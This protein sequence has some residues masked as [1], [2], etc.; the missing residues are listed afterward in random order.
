MD[1]FVRC[2]WVCLIVSG[3]VWGGLREAVSAP[4]QA[5]PGGG[6]FSDREA[7]PQNVLVLTPQQ[8][9]KGMAGLREEV[10]S[11]VKSDEMDELRRQIGSDPVPIP[12]RLGA[13]FVP[14]IIQQQN[15]SQTSY[16]VY[17]TKGRQ[18]AT[19]P[20]GKKA[21]VYPGRYTVQIGSRSGT[22]LPRYHVR[23]YASQLTIIR[24]RWAALVILVQDESLVQFRGT[25][26]LIHL[27]SRRGIGTGIGADER[28]GEKVRPWLLPPGLYMIVQVG[29][30]YLAR[31]DFLTVQV[32]EGEGTFFRLIKDR[33]DGRVRGG[34]VL[35]LRQLGLERQGAWTW[36]L[37]LSGNFL[38]N[39]V[40][41]VPATTP[42]HRFSLT[43][44]FTGRATYNTERHFF[45]SFLNV[46]LGFTIPNF[47]RID[48]IDLRKSADRVEL[49][50]IYIY[51]I[52]S[53]LGPYARVGLESNI[54]PG[55]YYI[56]DLE[57][58]IGASIF[59]CE[60]EAACSL[61]TDA[62]GSAAD[63]IDLSDFW[64]PLLIKQGLGV[65]LQALQYS[66]LDLR[67]LVGVGFRQEVARAVFQGGATT[68]S[69]YSARCRDPNL[70][71]PSAPWNT[72][73][74]PNTA[75][76][77]QHIHLRFFRKTWSHREGIE[78]AVVATGQITRFLTFTTEFDMLAP[79]TAFD[80]FDIT[81]RT[82][83]TLRLSH[84][85]SLFYR[86][87]VRRDPATPVVAGLDKW[88][89]D[90]SI[91]LSFSILL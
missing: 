36:S 42:G 10:R 65:N 3:I 40:E 89:F 27:E 73:R 57:R 61:L 67:V 47:S 29:D 39:N 80:D 45:R 55:T 74:C 8:L 18:V 48:Q 58:S 25:Y 62:K 49:E 90:Q 85:A 23:V 7:T 82:T 51:R 70:R 69:D 71:D 2:W 59:R 41:N 31:T 11:L 9:E 60:T 75:N 68:T 12:P 46:E 5:I 79:F 16:I 32:N 30:T 21:F 86:L 22:V 15:V 14:R 24:A 83:I 35:L 77:E 87:R 20:T 88:S 91:V 78:L 6:I 64:D 53:F 13:I 1:A 26:D 54:F 44:F 81:W 50:A 19:N 38:W 63:R 4:P 66:W 56:S 28:I 76:Q 17:D 84:Y 33:N 72:S 52:L 37:Q 43:T 34:G